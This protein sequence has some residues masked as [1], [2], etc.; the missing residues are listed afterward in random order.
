MKKIYCNVNMFDLFS[1][2]YWIDTESEKI[3]FIDQST[4]TNLPEALVTKAVAKN[5]MTIS[6]SGNIKYLNDIVLRI[7]EID[8]ENMFEIEVN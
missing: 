3:E 1:P 2:I 4:V 8:K 5:T 6:L 7:K